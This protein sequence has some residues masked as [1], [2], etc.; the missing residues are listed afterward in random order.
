[1]ALAD[2]DP[3][4]PGS[5]ERGGDRD[6]LIEVGAL[7]QEVDG[8]RLLGL[9]VEAVADGRVPALSVGKPQGRGGRGPVQCGP[10]CST[11]TCP[12]SNAYS[13]CRQSTSAL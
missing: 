11:A 6:N 12:S 5:G 4:V 1:V 9:G 3:P 2:L 10:P 13:D 7:Q 8:Q